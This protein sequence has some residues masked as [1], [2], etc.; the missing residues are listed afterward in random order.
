MLIDAGAQSEVLGLGA[1]CIYRTRQIDHCGF[2]D[3]VLSV[4]FLYLENMLLEE[5]VAR[6]QLQPSA[7]LN[8]CETAG[9]S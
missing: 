9:M 6:L 1:G 3:A 8:W 7:Y 4:F 5:L 2:I